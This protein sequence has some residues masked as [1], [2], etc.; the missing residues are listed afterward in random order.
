MKHIEVKPGYSVLKPTHSKASAFAQ[1][2]KKYE[3]KSTAEVIA[4]EPEVVFIKPDED[5]YP[6]AGLAPKVGDVVVYDDSHS[7]NLQ[8]D[9]TDYEIV[10]NNDILATIRE[11]N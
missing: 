5:F 10:N 9:G 11:E 1:E 2:H 8:L 6:P 7:V 4:F 3:R